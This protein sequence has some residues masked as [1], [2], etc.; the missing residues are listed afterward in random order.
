MCADHVRVG[1]G[2]P[3]LTIGGG[4]A[5]TPF[6][7]RRREHFDRRRRSSA[8]LASKSTLAHSGQPFP[9]SVHNTTF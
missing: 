9:N 5:P 2:V 3:S 7:R 4:G 6:W 1:G 8:A